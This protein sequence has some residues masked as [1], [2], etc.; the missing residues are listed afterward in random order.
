[1]DNVVSNQNIKV[2]LSNEEIKDLILSTFISYIDN[3]DSKFKLLKDE[4]LNVNINNQYLNNISDIIS[5]N[6]QALDNNDT[7][8]KNI[9]EIIKEIIIKL[10]EG[11]QTKNLYKRIRELLTKYLNKT[12]SK[13]FLQL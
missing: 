9:S 12:A 2:E 5:N 6:K 7:I 1:M 13:G 3:S 4:I 8:N 11:R 10:N